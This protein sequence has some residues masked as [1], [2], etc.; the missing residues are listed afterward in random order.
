[1]MNRYHFYPVKL[2][3]FAVLSCIFILYSCKKDQAG[4]SGKIELSMLDSVNKL[5]S[6]GCKC[7]QDSMPPVKKLT[8]N[9][10]LATAAQAHATDM[11]TNNYFS[12]ISPAGTSP[13]QRAISIG[14]T[15]QYVGENIAEGY[16]TIG[17][18]MLAWEKSDDH[19]KAMMDPLYIEMGAYSY[20]GYW[21]QEFGH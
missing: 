21:V 1:M 17:D 3:S 14:Y 6:R 9:S 7:G 13:I 8:W 15:G 5:R 16:A 10:V 18:V 4:K 2:L 20:N 19:C 11:Y 12:H